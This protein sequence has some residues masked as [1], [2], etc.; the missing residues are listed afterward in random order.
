MINGLIYDGTGNP[1]ENRPLGIRGDRIVFPS[2]DSQA[3]QI[4][5]INGLA[6]APGFIDAHG[7]SEFTILADPG[8]EGKLFQ[9]ITTEINGNCGLSAGPLYGD[10]L[11]HRMDDLKEYDIPYRWNTLREYFQILELIRP[12]LNFVT[13]VGH[14]NI[15]GSVMGF[16]QRTPSREDMERMILLLKEALR[17]G[18][19]GLSTGLIYPPGIYSSTEELIELVTEGL[20][21][22]KILN[23]SFIY[24]SHM[25][26]EA[27][28]LLEAIGEVLE[29][30]KRSGSPLH[31]S[32]LKTAGR[33]NWHKIEKV[34]EILHSAL[35]DGV[36]ISCDRYPYIASST[37]LD[38]I[39]PSWAFEGGKEKE[40]K[41]LRAP[42]TAKE[43]KRNISE[44]NPQEIVISSVE[45]KEKKWM[46]GKSLNEIA[47][48][49]NMEPSELIINLLIE[50]NLR[51]GAIFHS[52]NEKNLERLLREPFMSIGT[53]SS[54]RSY[55]GPT[56][57]GRPH[58]RGFGSMPRFL[59]IYC[60]EKRLFPLE[61]AIRK[62]TSLPA[63]I[64]GLKDRGIIKEGAFA[65]L[66]VFDPDK[67]IDRADF[68]NPFLKPDGIYHVF[69]NG[70]PALYNGDA[71]GIRNGRVLRNGE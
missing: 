31:I 43:I 8:Q 37:D 24:T 13:L 52:M 71:T 48:T 19:I 12:S 41:R 9:G 36:K 7:H 67:I 68:N 22:S 10:Y 6:I 23:K 18:A 32:H 26:S 58:P 53:D 21:F 34:L 66:V 59:G 65:D 11:N 15:R 56:A 1:P 33:E 55:D 4:I 2:K 47:K 51:V 28:R 50:E 69:V 70:L 57:K 63:K 62:I 46:E 44:I 42:D 20:G 64:F 60:R 61:E 54:S 16:K 49:L 27:E 25:R 38:S 14:G 3:E 35:E 29:I 40:L 45:D 5:D 39:L 30:A 17:D